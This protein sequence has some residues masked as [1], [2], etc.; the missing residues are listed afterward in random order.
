[1]AQE[2]VAQSGRRMSFNLG[3]YPYPDYE[4]FSF[5]ADTHKLKRIDGVIFDKKGNDSTSA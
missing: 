2:I 3:K 1:M 5:Y 4:P